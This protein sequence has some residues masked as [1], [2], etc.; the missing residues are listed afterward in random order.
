MTSNGSNNLKIS[1][2]MRPYDGQGDIIQW[3]TKVEL[4]AKLRGFTD[5]AAVIPLFLEGAAFS[6]YN[7]LGEEEKKSSDSVKK[8]LTD[9]FSINAFQAYELFSKR[10][11]CRGE[12]VDL[13][14]TDLRK[15]ARL[16]GISSDAIIMR[17]FVVG[18]PTSVSGQIRRMPKVETLPLSDIIDSARSLMAQE[19]KEAPVVAVARVGPGNGRQSKSDGPG[20]CFRCGGSHFVRNCPEAMRKLRCWTCGQDGHISRDCSENVSGKTGAPAVFPKEG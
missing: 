3:L 16:A 17:A 1:D 8:A 19:E 14:L 9:A 13:F 10:K 11:W 7:E 12:P 20:K 4:V 6:V 2:V 5:L 15:L 18:L